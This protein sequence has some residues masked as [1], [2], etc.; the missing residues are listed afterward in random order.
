VGKTCLALHAAQAQAEAFADGVT[1]VP[2]AGVTFG[3][4]VAATVAAALGVS[5]S[6]IGDL[7]AQLVSYLRPRQLLLVLDR[8]LRLISFCLAKWRFWKRSLP[9]PRGCSNAC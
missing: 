3:A 5:F 8:G 1:V 2:L 4:L 6:D 7:Q 9:M